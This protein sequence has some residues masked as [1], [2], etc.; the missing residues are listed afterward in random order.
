MLRHYKSVLVDHLQMVLGMQTNV[1]D[2]EFAS[3]K[4]LIR[5]KYLVRSLYERNHKRNKCIL[6]LEGAITLFTKMR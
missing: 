3:C 1:A 4:F 5:R 6:E 2:K